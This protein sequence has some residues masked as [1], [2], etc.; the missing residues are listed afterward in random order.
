MDIPWDDLRLFLAVAEAG[1]LSGAARRLRIGQPTVSRKLAALEYTLG[2]TLFR[3]SVDGATLT[4]A[5]ER[6]LLP[7]RKMADW[8]GEAGR[9]A[10]QRS[11]TPTGLVR[12]TAP[13]FICFDFVAPFAAW[14]SRQYPG[15]RLE[16]LSAMHHLDLARG[17]ADLALRVRVPSQ[18]ELQLVTTRVQ[19]NTVCVARSLA[20]KLPKR[21]RLEDVPWVSWAP[22][23]DDLPPNPQL[24]ELVPSYV[25][26]FTSDN[27]LVL[28]AA[29]E[30]GAGAIV[31]PRE[32]HRFSRPTPLVRLPIELGPHAT[33]QTHLVC[34]KSALDIPRI[35]LVCGLLET[36]MKRKVSAKQKV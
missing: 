12:V 15:L 30:A 2:A 5:G 29:A 23:F 28:L 33:S 27:F 3:R 20:A 4:S 10:E 14:V 6:L 32:R 1:S 25:P 24:R 26:A 18:P 35:R 21:P 19:H 31:L 8:A 22:P 34:A 9:A 7:A 36:E 11:S 17:E 16:V 13:P